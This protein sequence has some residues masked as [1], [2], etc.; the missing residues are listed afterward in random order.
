MRKL[1]ACSAFLLAA[2]F[3]FW[4]VGSAQDDGAP[5][6]NQ[7]AGYPAQQMPG[8]GPGRGPAGP[9]ATESPIFLAS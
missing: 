1:L 6:G 2:I 9:V 5:A 4:S 8:R 7:P 3:V